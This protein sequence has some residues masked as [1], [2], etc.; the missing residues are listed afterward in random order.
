MLVFRCL[1][2]GLLGAACLL[3]ATRPPARQVSPT[4]VVVVPPW[5]V[6]HE[7]PPMG[8]PVTV[9]DLAPG[10]SGELLVNLIVLAANEHVTAIDGQ[11]VRDARVALATL[12]MQPHQYVD[13][14]IASDAGASRRVL[15]L[16]R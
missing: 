15:V 14:S 7:A 9:I 4:E 11:P 5:S 16:P 2:V 8:P 1:V 13:V 10:V 6:H 3:F 12:A